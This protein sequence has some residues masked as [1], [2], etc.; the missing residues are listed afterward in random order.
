MP[1]WKNIITK[2]YLNVN[3]RNFQNSQNLKNFFLIYELSNS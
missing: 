2:I 1:K 3:R